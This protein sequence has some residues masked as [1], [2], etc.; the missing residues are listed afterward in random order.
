M[1]K[2]VFRVLILACVLSGYSSA[3]V[4]IDWNNQLMQ[5]IRTTSMNPPRAS[6]AM[7][8]VHTAVYDAVNS[9]DDTH[10]PYY[11]NLDVPA[12]TSREAAAAQAARDVLVNVFPAQAAGFDAMLNTHLSAIP[13]G[14]AK[15]DGI[16]LGSNVAAAIIAL[17]ANDHSNDVVPYT[18][19]GVPGKWEPTLP[20][21][22]PA[23]LP[24]WGLVTP[25]SGA[26]ASQFR[27]PIGPP[28]LTDAEYTQNF[29]EVKE[30][31]S[32]TSATRTQD[33]T[34]I[35]LFWADG[36]GTA[37]PPGHWNI[38]AQDI[39]VAKGNTLSENARMFALLN[40]A[41][42]DAGCVSWDNKFTFDFWRPVTGI[43]EADTDGNP[44]TEADPNW[45]PLIVTPPFPSYTSGHSTFSSAA[46]TVL[47]GFF[48]SDEISFTASAE[49][50]VAPD[51]SF[52]SLSQAAAEAGLSRIYGGIHWQFDNEDAAAGGRAL[53]EYILEHQL[54]AVP[55]PSSVL[56]IAIGVL[57]LAGGPARRRSR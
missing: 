5:S 30:L 4:V 31:G 22:A 54:L 40:I 15:T 41:T 43:R 45:E 34:N 28:S 47:A 57:A 56:L 14:Q 3:D 7:A 9:I 55:E 50:G 39:A 10:Q 13:D 8:M 46:A 6:R 23:L 19:S 42:A 38:I 25:W 48:G 44:D 53:G 33:Q 37:S 24:N 1:I 16:N 35:A 11:T 21:F 18:P 12:T 29:N 32:K 27:D 2:L 36:G 20:G 26:P 52:T 51:R 17:R 49:G